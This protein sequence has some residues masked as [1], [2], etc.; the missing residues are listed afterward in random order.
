MYHGCHG[1]WALKRILYQHRSKNLKTNVVYYVFIYFLPSLLSDQALI[2]GFGQQPCK[3]WYC[4]YKS[5][6]QVYS[7]ITGAHTPRSVRLT[8]C[9]FLIWNTMHCYWICGTVVCQL[10]H[11]SI[12]MGISLSGYNSVWGKLSVPGYCAWAVQWGCTNSPY[13]Q[14]LVIWFN[15]CWRVVSAK[16]RCHIFCGCKLFANKWG[17]WWTYSY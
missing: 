3:F 12:N 14:W 10:S 9:K 2:L 13:S 11:R 5:L 7:D 15:S 8:R 6:C 16:A 17:C 4:Y 1:F